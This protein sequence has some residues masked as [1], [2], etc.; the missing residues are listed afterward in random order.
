MQRLFL[1]VKCILSEGK[2]MLEICKANVSENVQ[3]TDVMQ[4]H[5]YLNLIL[6]FSINVNVYIQ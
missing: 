3:T 6:L 4:L 1:N 2:Q 5:H